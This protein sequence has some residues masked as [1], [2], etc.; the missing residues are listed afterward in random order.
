MKMFHQNKKDDNSQ[1]KVFSQSEK[2]KK[3]EKF[4]EE[5]QKKALAVFHKPIIDN[6]CSKIITNKHFLGL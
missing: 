2:K 5:A 1:T 3:E 6:L 4:K